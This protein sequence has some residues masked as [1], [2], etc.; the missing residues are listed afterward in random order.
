MDTI[1]FKNPTDKPVKLHM[2]GIDHT[3][4]PGSEFDVPVELCAPGRLDNGSR[5]RSPIECTCPQLV[6]AD[7]IVAAEWRKV[8]EPAPVVSRIVSVAPRQAPVPAGVKAA[9]EAAAMA[10]AAKPQA[11]AA[12]KPAAPAKPA[13]QPAAPKAPAQAPA[14]APAAEKASE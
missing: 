2:L 10:K 12:S 11:P 14:S 5:Q 3:M 1:T 9:R 13:S 8:P 4:E 6:P 7:P